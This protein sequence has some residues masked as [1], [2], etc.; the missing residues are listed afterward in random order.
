MAAFYRLDRITIKPETD[1]GAF[2]DFVSG[3]LLPYFDKTYHPLTRVTI[4]NLHGQSFLK[5]TENENEYSWLTIWSGPGSAI[6]DRSFREVLMIQ[7]P[8]T[9]EL[10]QR[11]DAFG[12][13]QTMAIWEAVVEPN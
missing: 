1:R 11:V 4:A 2:V 10:L 7:K 3:T 5:S 6:S 8:E 12:E 9:D 13:R